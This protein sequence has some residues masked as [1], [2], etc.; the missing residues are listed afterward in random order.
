MNDIYLYLKS[1]LYQ[2]LVPLSISLNVGAIVKSFTDDVAPI[3]LIITSIV[4]SILTIV[5]LVQKFKINKKEL[6]SLKNAD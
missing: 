5:T 6:E 2:V 3:I 4:I 1:H